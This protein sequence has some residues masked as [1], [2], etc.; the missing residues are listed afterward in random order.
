MAIRQAESEALA[1]TNTLRRD[2]LAVGGLSLVLA[3]VSTVVLSTRIVRPIGSL[4]VSARRIASGDLDSPISTT[5][6]D[7]IGALA[8]NFET[9]RQKLKQ[10]YEKIEAHSK[11]IE[12]RNQEREELLKC[13]IS[14]QEEERKRLARELHD[15][16]A[17]MLSALI[18][19]LEAVES[20]LPANLNGI[21]KELDDSKLLAHQGLDDI[22][23]LILNL[24]PAALDDLGLV[25]AI[26]WYAENYLENRGVEVSIDA[27]GL[28]T[29]LPPQLETALF[30][31][32]QEAINNISRHSAA[33][34]A[35]ISL[36]AY[37]S[38]VNITVEDNG[39][40][41]D[42]SQLGKSK[43]LTTGLGLL[44]MQE[45]ITL[46]GGSLHIL[47]QP[48]KGTR[49]VAEVPINSTEV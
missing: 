47:S 35:R 20:R 41:F 42:A 33:T 38:R 7:E 23:K 31:V 45:R 6:N 18:M 2:M 14:V 9:M 21:K 26:R 8:Q 44:G 13:I 49:I 30:R 12:Q 39:R 1:P 32:V 24:R 36:M 27:K 29:R 43:K 17:Q 4:T 15:E 48:G 11:T 22:R 10:S 25:S 19:R 5:G 40:G 46:L 16:T 34:A 37:D 28:G 3:M